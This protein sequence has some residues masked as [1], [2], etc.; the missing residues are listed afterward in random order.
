MARLSIVQQQMKEMLDHHSH[1]KNINLEDIALPKEQD[2]TTNT[3]DIMPN[4][5]PYFRIAS[6]KSINSGTINLE[7]KSSLVPSCVCVTGAELILRH[8]DSYKSC[9]GSNHHLLDAALTCPMAQ[10][11]VYVHQRL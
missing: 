7:I 4:T 3:V 10:F 11:V 9:L 2:T 1:L 6:L 8:H 5:P